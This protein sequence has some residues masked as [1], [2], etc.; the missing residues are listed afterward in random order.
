M[1]K[2]SI[3]SLFLL[4]IANISS[5]T[6]GSN[7]VPASTLINFVPGRSWTYKIEYKDPNFGVSQVA[8]DQVTVSSKTISIDGEIWDTIIHASNNNNIPDFWPLMTI[9]NDGIWA[10]WAADSSHHPFHPFKFPALIGE[11][12]RV[13]PSDTTGPDQY[14][15]KSSMIGQELVQAG[16]QSYL[17]NVYQHLL[18]GGHSGA[19]C[20][21]Y[22]A[23]SFTLVKAV[24]LS[25]NGSAI[26]TTICTL[27]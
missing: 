27:Q 19:L 21:I 24:Y 14:L 2:Y 7:N 6:Q 1:K 20:N 15:N 16:N 18:A 25:S 11:S 3:L 17:C 4:L 26:D 5:C 12:W 8:Y 22:I 23:P 10:R 13:S 9:R